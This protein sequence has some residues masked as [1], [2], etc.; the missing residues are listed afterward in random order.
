[1]G[2][3]DSAQNNGKICY[4][5]VVG[6]QYHKDLLLTAT[7]SAV[8]ASP[9]IEGVW[10]EGQLHVFLTVMLDTSEWIAPRYG[11]FISGEEIPAISYEILWATDR[12][13][14]RIQ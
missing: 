9:C 12:T 3:T 14:K 7:A 11:N 6:A 2:T 4:L 10:I 8:K 5:N 13:M 1:M